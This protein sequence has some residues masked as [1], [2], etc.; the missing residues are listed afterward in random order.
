MF[1][2]F[3]YRSDSGAGI[4]YLVGNVSFE[5]RGLAPGAEDRCCLT[6]A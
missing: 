6:M 5:A 4:T 1:G 2:R 3:E